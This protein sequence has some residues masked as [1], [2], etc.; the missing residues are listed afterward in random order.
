MPKSLSCKWRGLMCWLLAFFVLV[1]SSVWA[2]AKISTSERVAQ[3]EYAG[4]ILLLAAIMAGGITAMFIP[5]SV[6]VQIKRVAFAKLFIGVTF[7]LFASLF[8]SSHHRLDDVQMLL[9]AYFLASI[10]T[11]V[12]VYVV[13]IASDKDTYATLVTWFKRKFGL[14]G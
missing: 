10:G 5:T 6:D 9:P 12:M 14:G 1:P 8:V 3:F 4:T 2:A 11:P 13:G 7:G